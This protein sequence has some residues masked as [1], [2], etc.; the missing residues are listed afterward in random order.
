MADIDFSKYSNEELMRI[1]QGAQGGGQQASQQE[2][3]QP[4][5]LKSLGQGYMNYA[6]GALR[7]MGQ[8]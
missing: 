3:E 8:A 2:S 4:G 1:A 5:F 7:G 6:G